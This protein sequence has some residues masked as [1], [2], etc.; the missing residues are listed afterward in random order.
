MIIDF[1]KS[2]SN[3]KIDDEELVKLLDEKVR[4][5]PDE[6]LENLF[7]EHSQKERDTALIQCGTVEKATM[8]LSSTYSQRSKANS[9]L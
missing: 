4:L 9:M 3:N 8:Y 2:I 5:L 6:Q 1:Q 7:P